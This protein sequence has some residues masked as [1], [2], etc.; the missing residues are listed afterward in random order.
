MKLVNLLYINTLR[1]QVDP[2][3]ETQEVTTKMQ[4]HENQHTFCDAKE[5]SPEFECH[6]VD[7]FTRCSSSCGDDMVRMRRCE[8]YKEWMMIVMYE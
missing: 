2:D 6:E 1:A 5:L 4:V 8:C 7:N 3:T